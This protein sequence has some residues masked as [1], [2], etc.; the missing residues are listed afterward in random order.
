MNKAVTLFF[1]T[2]SILMAAAI[3]TPVVPA[4]AQGLNCNM[5][6]SESWFTEDIDVGYIYISSL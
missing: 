2:V 1:V 3:V 6:L 5:G 4:E